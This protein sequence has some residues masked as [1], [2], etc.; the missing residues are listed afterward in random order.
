MG[1]DSIGFCC[2]KLLFV[3][4]VYKAPS[5]YS[6]NANFFCWIFVADIEANFSSV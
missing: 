6:T 2:R 4:W 1:D 3:S 5:N